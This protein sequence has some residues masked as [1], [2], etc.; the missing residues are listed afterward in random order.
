VVSDNHR[1]PEAGFTLVELLVTM[2]V[3]SVATVAMYQILFNVAE[4]TRTTESLARISDEARL[5]FNR[6]V[7]DTR[8]GQEIRAVT[9]TNPFGF[10]VAVDFDGN[11][12]ITSAPGENSS[13]DQEELTYTFDSSTGQVRL[14][15]ELLMSGVGCVDTCASNPPFDYASQDLRYD[16]NQNGVTT[17]QELDKA[18]AQGVVGIGD[19]DDVLDSSELPHVTSVTFRLQV[20]KGDSSS[21]FYAR[22][23]LR[24]KR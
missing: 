22:A 19:N 20:T 15:G 12:V 4:G 10:T 21:S 16:W 2:L 13:G 9:M 6:M 5:G 14:N 18:P 7:R 11:G 1:A 8:E 23:Q 24:N 3:L 17:W